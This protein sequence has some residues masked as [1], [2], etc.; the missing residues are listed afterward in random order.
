MNLFRNQVRKL[1]VVS[2]LWDSLT[3]SNGVLQTLLIVMLLITR[4]K[5]EF[6][7]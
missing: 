1:I 6:N 4:L 2:S 7:L 5:E 3:A